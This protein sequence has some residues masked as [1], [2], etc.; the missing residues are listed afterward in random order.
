[1]MSNAN[2]RANNELHKEL[3]A[4]H[5]KIQEINANTNATLMEL[6]ATQ[7]LDSIQTRLLKEH[8]HNTEKYVTGTTVLTVVTSDLVSRLHLIGSYLE[9]IHNSI[10]AKILDL[11]YLSLLLESN[12]LQD[13]DPANIEHDAT[14]LIIHSDYSFTLEFVGRRHSLDTRVYGVKSF[15]HWG[16]ILSDTPKYYEY[17]CIHN[18]SGRR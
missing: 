12:L 6:R 13:L 16:D 7:E 11:S 4:A 9:M 8:I 14:M 2:N 3:A 5:N 15:K 17:L 1:M 10:I 18:I